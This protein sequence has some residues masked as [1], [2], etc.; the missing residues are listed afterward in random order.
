M[1][2][3]KKPRQDDTEEVE[4]PEPQAARKRIAELLRQPLLVEVS[5]VPGEP[6]AYEFTASAVELI[7]L[8]A[9]VGTPIN[10]L[11]ALFG[12]SESWLTARMKERSEL[13]SAYDAADA[14]GRLELRLAQH[15]MA[16]FNAQMA[17]HLGKT[18]LRQTEEPAKTEHTVYVV[19]AQAQFSMSPDEWAKKFMPQDIASNQLPAPGIS[20]S[21][22][23][24]APRIEEAE[25]VSG[26]DNPDYD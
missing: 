21:K 17:I 26:D 6:A 19:G 23:L 12:R 14:A 22:Q 3:R 24:Q 10:E 4:K 5:V 20:A 25:L 13:Q 18:R 1:S 7:S 9:V 16:Q 11:A 8:S 15:D 2:R